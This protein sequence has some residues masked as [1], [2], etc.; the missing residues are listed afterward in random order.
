ML[1]LSDSWK[2]SQVAREFNCALPSLLCAYLRIREICC[3]DLGP[4]RYGGN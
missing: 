1:A 4:K 3:D 2:V